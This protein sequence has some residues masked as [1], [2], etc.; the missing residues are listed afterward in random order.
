MF[1]VIQCG[2]FWSKVLGKVLF[3][4]HIPHICISFFSFLVAGAQNTSLLWILVLC[5]GGMFSGKWWLGKRSEAAG[6]EGSAADAASKTLIQLS[7]NLN[8]RVLPLSF[9]YRTWAFKS[10][11]SMK[12][13]ATFLST[14]CFF[15][16]RSRCQS[17]HHSC[18]LRPCT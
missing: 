15:A 9:A 11:S 7:L 1:S 3:C 12:W 10:P 18:Q 14:S 5:V 2:K 16:C 4:V 17:S 6:A 13:K 8:S